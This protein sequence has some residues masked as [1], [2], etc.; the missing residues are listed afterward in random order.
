M[1][2]I[3]RTSQFKKDLKRYQND[4]KKLQALVKT[5]NMLANDE[6]LPNEMYPHHLTGQYASYMECHIGPDYLL[7]WYDEASNILKLIRLGSHSEL[8][9]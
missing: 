4:K 3:K 8:F 6:P 2:R 9:G 1:K 7:I 5:I